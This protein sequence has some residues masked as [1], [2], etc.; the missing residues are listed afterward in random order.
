MSL[1]PLRNI[2]RQKLL[3]GFLLVIVWGR[4]WL[5]SQSAISPMKDIPEIFNLAEILAIAQIADL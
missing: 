3:T 2:P 4:I 5:S 1:I